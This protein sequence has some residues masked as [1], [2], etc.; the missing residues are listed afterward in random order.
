M[1]LENRQ[2]NGK[3]KN[4]VYLF[5]AG[6]THAE[7]THTVKEKQVKFNFLAKKGLLMKDV[8]KR[9]TRAAQKKAFF[10][11]IRMFA[12]QNGSSNIE[13]LISLIEDNNNQIE[14]SSLITENLK[15]LVKTDIEGILNDKKIRRKFYLHKALLELD[16]ANNDR[17]KVLGYISLNYDTVL[18]DAYCE[19]KKIKEPNYCISPFHGHQV[20]NTPLLKLHGSFKWKTKNDI[21]KMLPTIPLGI[22]KNYLQLPYSFIWGHAHEILKQCDELRVIGCSLSQNDYRLIDLLFKAHLHKKGAFEIHIIGFDESGDSVKH[23]Y[24]F[25]NGIKNFSEIFG[26]KGSNPKKDINESFQTWLKLKAADLT[27]GKVNRTKYL[28]RLIK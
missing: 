28:K 8:S 27:S 25:F 22:N 16:R 24:E 14:N 9:V 15:Q 5:G 18:D 11:N 20:K 19:I 12:V 10:D 1:A 6:A 3:V 26:T 13:L 23:N 21:V 2:T 17:E 4:V 7:L